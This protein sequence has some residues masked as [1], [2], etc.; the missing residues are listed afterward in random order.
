MVENGDNV[1]ELEDDTPVGFDWDLGLG[2]YNLGIDGTGSRGDELP[3]GG[4]GGGGQPTPGGSGSGVGG[5][6]P[7]PEASQQPAGSGD[8]T[9][10]GG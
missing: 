5:G 3:A 7:I 4:G 1:R 10:G 9:P 6:L 2:L 8:L